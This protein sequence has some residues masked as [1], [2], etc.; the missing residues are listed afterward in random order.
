[1]VYKLFLML[2]YIT[3]MYTLGVYCLLH[4]TCYSVSLEEK[5]RCSLHKIIVRD[6]FLHF[7]EGIDGVFWNHGKFVLQPDTCA[8]VTPSYECEVLQFTYTCSHLIYTH[9]HRCGRNWGP[10]KRSNDL[11]LFCFANPGS[12]LLLQLQYRC[13]SINMPD[14]DI[15]FCKTPSENPRQN[16]NHIMSQFIFSSES[17]TS[18]RPSP[19]C[20]LYLQ[21]PATPMYSAKQ[22]FDG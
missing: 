13:S 10:Q 14:L 19:Q 20:P 8:C 1:M 7:M 6:S 21:G 3:K 18:Y 4:S 2:H 22:S 15:I 5:K 16:P 11:N 12:Y 17:Q 9:F